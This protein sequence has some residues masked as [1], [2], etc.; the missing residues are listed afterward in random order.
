MNIGYIQL[1]RKL[2]DWEWYSDHNTFRVFIHCLLK[3]NY[4]DKKW[5]GDD[6]PRGSFPS[7][8]SNIGVEIGLTR[9][10]VRTALEK[11]ESTNYITI[12]TT[13]KFSLITIVKYTDYQTQVTSDLTI[14]QPST[15]HQLTTPKEVNNIKKEKKESVSHARDYLSELT[16]KTKQHA[17]TLK[18]NDSDYQE[19]LFYWMVPSEYDELPRWFKGEFFDGL[20]KV[21]NWMRQVEAKDEE[22]PM[23]IFVKE[24]KKKE[25]ANEN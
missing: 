14:N 2:L 24:L 19:F 3:A 11:L 18:M 20:Q 8:P 13:N 6:I 16:I 7:S 5:K 9:Q 22:T 1:H 17:L 15:N 23:G 12:K 10:K 21:K 4:V 25:A